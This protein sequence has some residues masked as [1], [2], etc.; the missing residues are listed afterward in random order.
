MRAMPDKT[1]NIMLMALIALGGIAILVLTW[2]QS[3]PLSAR[4]VPSLVGIAGLAVVLG[5]T[6]ILRHRSAKV[7]ITGTSDKADDKKD[8]F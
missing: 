3:T 5:W 2:R 4:I 8:S 1:S 6:L 7:R